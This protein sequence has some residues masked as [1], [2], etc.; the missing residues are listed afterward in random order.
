MVEC[1]IALIRKYYWNLIYLLEVKEITQFDN[2][3]NIRRK[4]NVK[5]LRN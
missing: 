2:K 3:N 4:D 1:N 5:N